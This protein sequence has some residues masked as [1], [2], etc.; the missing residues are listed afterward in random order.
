[1]KG[2]SSNVCHR[3]FSIL[4]SESLSWSVGRKALAWSCSLLGRKLICK[5][6][7]VTWNSMQGVHHTTCRWCD[8]SA[9]W[10]VLV[11]FRGSVV[12]SWASSEVVL[13]QCRLVRRL[14]AE[15]L[16]HPSSMSCE[17][18]GQSY[19]REYCLFCL[20][21]DM[22]GIVAVLAV[23]TRCATL[24]ASGCLGMPSLQVACV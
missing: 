1:M 4:I 5:S 20:C 9:C 6:L 17:I 14:F 23:L 12:L 7:L 2:R 22:L 13:L 15:G 21:C 18:E 11:C 24:S 3:T 10:L 19:N 16:C 8:G